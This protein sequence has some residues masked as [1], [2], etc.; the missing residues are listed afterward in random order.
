[1]RTNMR[2]DVREFDCN[3]VGVERRLPTVDRQLRYNRLNHSSLPRHTIL[4]LQVNERMQLLP[5]IRYEIL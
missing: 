3:M 2:R 1:M 4:I 5:Y